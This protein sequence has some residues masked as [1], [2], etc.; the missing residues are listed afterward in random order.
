MNI[1]SSF[2]NVYQLASVQKLGYHGRL[3]RIVCLGFIFYRLFNFSLDFIYL[4][5]VLNYFIAARP[6]RF[7]GVISSESSGVG[8]SKDS[9]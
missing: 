3:K 7:R 5:L 8:C 6:T 9:Y 4:R 1:A 2:V